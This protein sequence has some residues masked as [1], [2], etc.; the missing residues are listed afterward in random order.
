MCWYPYSSKRKSDCRL[1][2]TVP[3]LECEPKSLFYEDFGIESVVGRGGRQC[4]VEGGGVS[5]F[6]TVG[7]VV[8]VAPVGAP[9][10]L[11]FDEIHRVHLEP[12]WVLSFIVVLE[13]VVE[14]FRECFFRQ[15]RERRF[16]LG[17]GIVIHGHVEVDH[18][19]RFDGGW[20]LRF[21]RR[22]FAVRIGGGSGCAVELAV[23][24]LLVV[25]FGFVR[26]IVVRGVVLVHGFLGC[27]ASCVGVDVV[28]VG[29]DWL[30]VV[31]GRVVVVFFVVFVVIDVVVGLIFVVF[32]VGFEGVFGGGGGCFVVGM[33]LVV[34]VVGVFFRG[35][36]DGVLDGVLLMVGGGRFRGRS[37]VRGVFTRWFVGG[38]ALGC[39]RRGE[40]VAST[41]RLA[42]KGGLGMDVHDAGGQ[43][44]ELGTAGA[45]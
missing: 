16:H 27:F 7:A 29:W 10:L 8:V 24:C 20:F 26:C 2:V 14:V 28:V 11:G 34:L 36:G 3:K 40:F 33:V 1:V 45:G 19:C 18:D 13:H 15:T 22:R 5:S 39:C 38:R 43:V 41:R 44:G 37:R 6:W 23:V 4:H 31:D 35:D 30:A 21:L 9:R 12:H 25:I 32:L 17:I 42:A